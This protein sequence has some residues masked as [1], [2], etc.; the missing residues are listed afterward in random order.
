MR[1]NLKLTMITACLWDG[2]GETRICDA[3]LGGLNTD[4]WGEFSTFGGARAVLKPRG[5]VGRPM[6]TRC[7]GQNVESD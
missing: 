2:D 6:A 1:L 4:D 3:A 5:A 7:P